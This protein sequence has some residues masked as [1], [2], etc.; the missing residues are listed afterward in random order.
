MRRIAVISLGLACVATNAHAQARLR[1]YRPE[2]I[3]SVPFVAG[4]DFK[5]LLDERLDMSNQAP[6]EVIVGVGLQ[7]P[8]FHRASA[9][10]EVRHVKALNGAI[11]HRYVPTLY[12]NFGLPGGFELR[13]R[14]RLELRAANGAWSQRY[15]NRSAIGHDVSVAD[16]AVF[17]YLQSDIFYDTRVGY[18]NRRDWTVGVRAP[19]T[20]GASIDPFLTRSSDT[21]RVP[22]LGF[23]AGAV[24]RVAL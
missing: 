13:S 12:T 10:F 11:E 24:L 2:L 3:L 1:E 15:I 16:R 7:S 4:V 8:Q 23:T 17:P 6:N 18:L 9:A 5:F 21:S 22:H 14:D 20:S 19:L